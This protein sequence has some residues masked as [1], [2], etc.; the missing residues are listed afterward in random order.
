MIE[1]QN[2]VKSYGSIR[3]LR[4][5]SMQIKDTGM[6]GLVGPN[7]AGKTTLMRILATILQPTEGMVRIF[8]YDVT[9]RTCRS[10][11]KRLLGYLPQELGFYSELTPLEFLEYVSA[12][13]GVPSSLR[14]RQVHELIEAVELTESSRRSIKTLSGGMKRRL[15]IAQALLGEP[16]LIIVDEPTAG[17]D[18]EERVRLRNLLSDL[19]HARLVIL[20]THIIEDIGQACAEMAILD[21]GRIVFIGA[22]DELT[23]RL[24]GKV[25]SITKGNPN[26]QEGLLIAS[27]RQVLGG[28]Q[29]RVIGEIANRDHA[30][31]AE[32]S[33]EDAYL[34]LMRGSRL[35][36]RRQ[37]APQP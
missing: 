7:G 5:I 26:L 25:W 10:Q 36:E 22:P 24:E 23:K 18:P 29:Y 34:W 8:G 31:P 11:I 3:A 20:S 17:L 16:R 33:L 15:G 4:G 27:Q 32:P 1:I 2:L 30:I 28:I 13:K 19:A 14:R 35:G 37:D 21:R 9:D 6:Y 12:L